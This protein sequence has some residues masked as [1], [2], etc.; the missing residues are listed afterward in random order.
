MFGRVFAW[1]GGVD[2]MI[3]PFAAGSPMA[4]FSVDT[5]N[6]QIADNRNRLAKLANGPGG[7]NPL[8]QRVVRQLELSVQILER[9]RDERAAKEARGV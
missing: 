1:K 2:G 9:L 4:R 6:H 3:Q 7:E 8:I 5:L